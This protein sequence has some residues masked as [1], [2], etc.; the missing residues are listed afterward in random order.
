M[1]NKLPI[2]IR[3]LSQNDVIQI[4]DL[5]ISIAKETE[6]IDLPKEKIQNGVQQMLDN[7]ELGQYFVVEHEETQEIVACFM[8]TYEWDE[9]KNGLIWW[10]QSVYVKTQFRRKGVYSRMHNFLKELAIKNG[11]LG[12]KLYVEKKNYRAQQAYKKMG[13]IP[14]DTYFFEETFNKTN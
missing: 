2:I 1:Q 13:M 3:K 10:I 8:N 4:A 12:L 6:N 14:S 7:P 9:I 11:A 5:N